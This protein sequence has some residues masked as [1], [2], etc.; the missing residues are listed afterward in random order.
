[1]TTEKPWTING[2][3][4]ASR[5]AGSHWFDPDTMR[6]FGTKVLPTVYQG[7]GGIFF[8]TEDD[9]YRRELPRLCTVRKWE[10]AN[11]SI[12]TASELASM[13]RKAAMKLARALATGNGQTDIETTSEAFKEVSQLDQF[14]HDLQK[15]TRPDRGT[16]TA[17]VEA[18]RRL[19]S[20]AK[21]HHKHMEAQCNG[22]WP[23]GKSW[24]G[25]E[26]PAIVQTCRDSMADLAKS[27]GATSVIFSGDPRGCTAKLTFADGYTND[28]GREG[29]CIPIDE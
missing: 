18:A 27:I 21:Q 5:A 26:H 17:T 15:H 24:D 29:Y 12:G 7:E 16:E 23:Y 2:I 3:K 28:F 8:V 4:E 14:A 20:L 25:E 22:T 6:S 11:A 19:M 1:M 13:T 9:Q 10:P